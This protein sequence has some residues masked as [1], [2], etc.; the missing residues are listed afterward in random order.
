MAQSPFQAQINGS[1]A[2]SAPCDTDLA[3]G[4]AMQVKIALAD[5]SDAPFADR[6]DV[7]VNQFVPGSVKPRSTNRGRRSSSRCGSVGWAAPVGPPPAPPTGWID[8]TVVDPSG[9][10]VPGA[11]V[12]ICD[13][14]PVPRQGPDARNRFEFPGLTV[15]DGYNGGPCYMAALFTSPPGYAPTGPDRRLV[16]VG[17]GMGVTA[18]FVVAHEVAI[19]ATGTTLWSGTDGAAKG[20]S[21]RSRS[22]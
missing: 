12:G 20:H 10:P 14:P 9:A 1:A 17:N 13:A 19:A 2:L 22:G 8:I 4:T 5:D 16:C 7:Q 15:V 18:T 21:Y 11:Q 6:A 3:A